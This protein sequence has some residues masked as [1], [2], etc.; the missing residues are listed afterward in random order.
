MT[1]VADEEWA[2]LAYLSLSEYALWLDTELRRRMETDL[3]GCEYAPSRNGDVALKHLHHLDIP[4]TYIMER[5]AYFSA[6]DNK[7][8][9]VVVAKSIRT[10]A[11]HFF[12]VRMRTS[13]SSRSKNNAFKGE[14]EVRHKDL[15]NVLER[16]RK[17]TKQE[18]E[19][20]TVYIVKNLLSGI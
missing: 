9:E 16:T 7:P 3:E 1:A 13:L 19:G 12:E 5:S 18:W 8:A 4:L 6:L 2:T 11:S 15:Q 10:H 14:F 17:H 20:L